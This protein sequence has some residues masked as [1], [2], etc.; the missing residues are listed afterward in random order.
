MKKFNNEFLLGTATAA[1]QVEGN[2]IYS[3]FWAQEQSD[4]TGF[5]E[6]SLDA[7]DHYHRYE[8]DIEL[9]K[10]AGLNAYRFSIEWARIEP[11]K[12]HFDEKEVE[13]YRKVIECC[14]KNGIVPF[15]TLHHFS[16][17]KWLITEGGWE[18]EST[19]D[20]F[21]RYCKYIAKELGSLLTYVCTI[22]E[23][24]MGLQIASISKRIMKQM[25][26]S[27]QV[28]MNFPMQER[29]KAIMETNMKIFGVKEGMGA[30]T[31]F[32]P[33]TDNGDLIIARAHAKARDA[34]K[35]ICP[36]IKIGLSL[37]LHD[38]Q[39][40]EDSE[41]VREIINKEWNSEFTHYLPY[42]ANDD[43][44]GVQNYTRTV[45]NKN[46]DQEAPKKRRPNTN[47]L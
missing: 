24:N 14:K 19:I 21:A 38:F 39:S 2:N 47:G 37:S 30:N 27:L 32:Q 6:K 20:Y 45:F 8:E 25:S 34:I 31:F 16:S 42:I 46:G 26:N 29:M 15:V 36:N 11:E 18:A 3:D 22:N 4:L 23:A 40:I 43:F 44:I 17:P 1:H 41:E 28:G 35:E 7:C 10:A 12:G 5:A 33:R 9:M 13:H